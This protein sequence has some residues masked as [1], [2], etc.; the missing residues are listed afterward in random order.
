[1]LESVAATVAVMVAVVAMGVVAVPGAVTVVDA[2]AGAVLGVVAALGE[3]RPSGGSRPKPNINTGGSTPKSAGGVSSPGTAATG[4]ATRP[5]NSV[6]N[7]S[8]RWIG[9]ARPALEAIV[10]RS[11]DRPGACSPGTFMRWRSLIRL[12]ISTGIIPGRLSGALTQILSRLAFAGLRLLRLAN[13]KGS[14]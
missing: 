10:G 9:R 11:T 5:R 8:G 4:P 6:A 12:P 7:R 2:V 3:V 1:M 13:R 14:T